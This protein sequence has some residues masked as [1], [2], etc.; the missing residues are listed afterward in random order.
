MAEGSFCQKQE[1]A[2]SCKN[3]C[4]ENHHLF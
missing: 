2:W 4:L 3:Y 1:K